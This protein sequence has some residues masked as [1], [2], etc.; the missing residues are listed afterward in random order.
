MSATGV[1]HVVHTIDAIGALLVDGVAIFKNGFSVMAAVSH[2]TDLA[3]QIKV[4]ATEAAQALP[5]LAGMDTADA[6]VVAGA[7][8]AMVQKFVAAVGK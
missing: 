2:G 4:L 6:T 5:E 7:A 1:V 8:Y 3:K